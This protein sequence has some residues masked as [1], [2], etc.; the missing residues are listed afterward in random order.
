MHVEHF[1][2]WLRGAIQEEELYV[3]HWRKM[4]DILQVA[5]CG[6]TLSGKSMCQ[7]LVL[8]PKGDNG[9]FRGIGIVEILWNT[10]TG[11]L[12]PRFTSAIG[13]HDVLHGLC[14]GYGMGTASLDAKL[15]QKITDTRE[16]V[17]HK[18]LLNL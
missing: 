2:K 11:L 1:R 15:I 5:L 3:T 16:A 10:I 7:M 13:F 12:N 14:A 17:L 4:T 6:R 9:D 8:I 18:N